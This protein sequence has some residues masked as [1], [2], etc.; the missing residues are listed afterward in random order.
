MQTLFT[1]LCGNVNRYI[2]SHPR[3]A[4]A[5]SIDVLRREG[6]FSRR[7]TIGLTGLAPASVEILFNAAQIAHLCTF[8]RSLAAATSRNLTSL[9]QP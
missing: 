1:D 2:N 5:R 6:T 4:A 8:K 7:D 9:T 3:Q